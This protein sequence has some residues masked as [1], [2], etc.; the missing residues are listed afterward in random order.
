MLEQAAVKRR[1]SLGSIKALALA[2]AAMAM[3]L[4]AA[5]VLAQFVPSPPPQPAQGPGGSDYRHRDVGASVH[6]SGVTQFWL[7]EPAQPTPRIAPVV[8]FMHGWGAVEPSPYRAWIDHIVRRGNIVI[9]PRY[10][11]DQRTGPREFTANAIGA[12]RAALELLKSDGPR[13]RADLARLAVVGHSVGGALSVNLA[14]S[15]ARAGLPPPVAVMSIQPGK[16]WGLP[17][18][19]AIALEDLSTLPPG[20]L[21]L[22]VAGDRDRVARDIDARR[23]YYGASRIPPQN[24]N[25]VLV[26]SDL[27]GSP[28]LEA[29]HLAP[30][31]RSGAAASPPAP[32][33]AAVRERR[34]ERRAAR[35]DTGL[36]PTTD[37]D[38]PEDRLPDLSGVTGTPPDALDFFAFWKLF[39][40][41]TDAAFHGKNREFALGNTP[42]Q[43]GMGWWSDGRPVREMIVF[44]RP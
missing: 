27:Y 11:A 18:R 6:G 1:L 23:I 21:L 12:V 30:L 19:A 20:M 41:L 13:A 4:G 39:D 3:A 24:K 22:V 29:H 36:A 34:A 8:I 17:R 14:A 7:F 15:A 38:E 10:Q 33:A 42:Q 43:R 2:A 28:P 16:T 5:D 37:G 25:F 31:A 35:G 9:Y 44:E 40:A 26:M 32:E